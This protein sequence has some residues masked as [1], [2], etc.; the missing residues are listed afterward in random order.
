MRT[1]AAASKHGAMSQVIEANGR[2]LQDSGV[3]AAAGDEGSG[4]V[5]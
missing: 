2:G 3:D 5:R 4:D 1:L